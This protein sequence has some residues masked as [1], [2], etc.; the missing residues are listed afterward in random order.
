MKRISVMI[1]ETWHL[2]IVYIFSTEL[3]TRTE[4]LGKKKKERKSATQ[5]LGGKTM[6][7]LW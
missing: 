5:R 2:I 6:P 4:K 7:C 3:S 1:P